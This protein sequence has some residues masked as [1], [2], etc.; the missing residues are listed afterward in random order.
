VQ[1][2]Y[3]GEKISLG[4]FYCKQ[5]RKII[6]VKIEFHM[7]KIIMKISVDEIRPWKFSTSPI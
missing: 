1:N 7:I 3:Q 4:Y 2:E 5:I 6:N